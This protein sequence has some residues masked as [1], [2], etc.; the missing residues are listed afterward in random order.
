MEPWIWKLF[1]ALALGVA[2]YGAAHSGWRGGERVGY[3]LMLALAGFMGWWWT[4]SV[5]VA[6]GGL[7]L[8]FL[9]PG[10][11]ALWLSRQLRFSRRSRLVAGPI[12][13]EEF[14][15]IN[16]VSRDVRGEGF[17]VLGDYWLRP[18]PFEQGYRLFAAPGGRVLAVA[19]V[20][21]QGLV[22][23]HYHMLLTRDAEGAAWLT[24]N[25]PLAYG[26]AMPPEFQVYRCLE[27]E[28][29]PQLLQQHQAFLEAN[30]VE[31]KPWA[32]GPEDVRQFDK[33]LRSVLSH[34]L[35]TGILRGQEGA[36]IGYSWRGSLLVSWQVVREIAL[37]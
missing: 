15:E 26:L 33:L 25:Y 4:G 17:Q 21:R 7:A 24:W 20:V 3:W 29:W 37:G 31:G 22:T 12:D 8:W 30:G 27:A 35:R 36:E 10:I 23:V 9:V 14:P 6:L 18:S 5:G 2:A 28:D 16:R 34:N 13:Y 11:Q 1:V 32:C 19:A